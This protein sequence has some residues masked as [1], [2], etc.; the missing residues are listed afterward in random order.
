MEG[1]SLRLGGERGVQE[2]PQVMG[3]PLATTADG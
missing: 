3:V 1:R 2:L